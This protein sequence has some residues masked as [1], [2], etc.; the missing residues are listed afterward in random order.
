[1]PVTPGQIVL[2]LD[3]WRMPLVNS[4]N[5]TIKNIRRATKDAFVVPL[6]H[7]FPWFFEAGVRLTMVR[8]QGLF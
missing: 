3:L 6:T 5:C 4:N 1:V 7:R 2:E 8:K